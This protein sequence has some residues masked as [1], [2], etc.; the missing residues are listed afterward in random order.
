MPFFPPVLKLRRKVVVLAALLFTLFGCR[1]ATNDLIET[2]A[3]ERPAVLTTVDPVAYFLR[4]LSGEWVTVETLVPA[5]KEPETFAPTPRTVQRF[6]ACAIFFR[7]GLVCEEPLLP[8]L[9]AMNPKMKTVDLRGA[10]PESFHDPHTETARSDG[11]D[12]TAPE[13]KEDAHD[14]SDHGCDCGE[15]GLDPHLWMSPAVMR[16]VVQTMAAEL[17]TLAPEHRADFQ[18]NRDVLLE[19]LEKLDREIS[20]RLEGLPN[21]T[22]YVFHPAYG[23]YCRQFGLR[24]R[25]LEEGGRAPSPKDLADWIRRI[26]DERVSMII[27]QPEFGA[28]QLQALS[29]AAHVNIEI[30]SPL[31]TDYFANL[32]GLTDLLSAD[33]PEK[34]EK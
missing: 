9:A 25:A 1:D 27:A 12:H 17:E 19:R 2:A 22:L 14:H 30:H 23:Y 6:A 32:R 11:S 24:Q 21:R 34:G 4:E 20:E 15:D 18:R 31:Q 33:G 8:R 29:E 7:V 5:G 28:S 10:I 13:A 3:P 16:S 26:G